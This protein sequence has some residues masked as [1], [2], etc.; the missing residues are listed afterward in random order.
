M[1][2]APGL[3]QTTSQMGVIQG[4]LRISPVFIC[5][6]PSQGKK[7][8]GQGLMSVSGLKYHSLSHHQQKFIPQF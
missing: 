3:K 6:S 2:P 5:Y 8:R 1:E 4:Q 7:S